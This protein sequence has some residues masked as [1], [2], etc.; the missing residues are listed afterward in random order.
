MCA[1]YKLKER[2]WEGEREGGGRRRERGGEEREEGRGERGGRGEERLEGV[3][4]YQCSCDLQLF[5]TMLYL[6]VNLCYLKY[7]ILGGETNRI[8][9][10]ICDVTAYTDFSTQVILMKGCHY[11][12]HLADLSNFLTYYV[13][14][15]SYLS[16]LSWY[17]EAIWHANSASSIIITS[18]LVSKFLVYPGTV[19]RSNYASFQNLAFHFY[20][21]I[22]PVQ[23][24]PLGVYIN[25]CLM[26]D[27]S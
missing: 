25:S 4:I 5:C 22:S 6:L 14:V 24:I 27:M 21:D 2:E 18:L 1:Q 10:W 13:L 26:P 11:C 3:S 7:N 23:I 16:S 9:M 17:A 12:H 19:T 15:P 20:H 8:F